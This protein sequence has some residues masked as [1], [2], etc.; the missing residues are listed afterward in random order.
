[1]GVD[2]CAILRKLFLWLKTFEYRWH[3]H[4][5][6]DALELELKVVLFWFCDCDCELER[7]RG[8]KRALQKRH[9]ADAVRLRATKLLGL[10]DEA[11]RV[12]YRCALLKIE[13]GAL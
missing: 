1:M 2:C 4:L 13:D 3:W 10:E 12:A 8:P 5:P 7:E 11:T 9:V 6:Y